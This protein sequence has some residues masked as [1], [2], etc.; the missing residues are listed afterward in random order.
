[1]R[2]SAWQE[3]PAN[4]RILLEA[5]GDRLT[6]RQRETVE[7]RLEAAETN[8]AAAVCG[9]EDFERLLVS[10][11]RGGYGG[12]VP[13]SLTKVRE[14][15]AYFSA[16]PDMYVTKLAKLHVVMPIFCIYREGNDVDHWTR[17]RPCASGTDPRQGTSASA[18]T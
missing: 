6:P 16:L 9:D 3:Q 10:R 15:V 4:V 7:S 11:A 17:L 5:N 14:V 8:D 2:S 13:L 1:M 18:P 12:N